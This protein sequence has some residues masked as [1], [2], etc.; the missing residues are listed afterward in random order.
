[1]FVF[2]D[3]HDRVHKIRYLKRKKLFKN[4]K[5]IINKF[6]MGHRHR[7][8]LAEKKPCINLQGEMS[9]GLVVLS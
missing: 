2:V 9:D 3:V 4:K 5:E 8:W 6:V 1:M 7:F